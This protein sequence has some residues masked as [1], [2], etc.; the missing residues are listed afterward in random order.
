MRIRKKDGR[1]GRA[2]RRRRHNEKSLVQRYC[3]RKKAYRNREEAEA[4]VEQ[5][6][7]DTV[8]LP[9]SPEPEVY[10]CRRCGS[11]HVGHTRAWR[12]FTGV[13]RRG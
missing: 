12:S 8:Y 7:R 5:L 13:Y 10:R 1:K 4:R 11:L 3:T 9:E 6:M 2:F